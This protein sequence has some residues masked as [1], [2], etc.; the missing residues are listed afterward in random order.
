MS[1]K[2][3]ETGLDEP[4]EAEIEYDPAKLSCKGCAGRCLNDKDCS[5]EV[6]RSRMGRPRQ[7]CCIK[8]KM[9]EMSRRYYRRQYV[10][11]AKMLSKVFELKD[12]SRLIEGHKKAGHEGQRCKQRI[13][14]RQNSCPI[15]A[16][17]IDNRREFRGLDRTIEAAI[18][19]AR[20]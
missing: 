18:A 15:L 2:E 10:P 16:R 17:L 9:R 3:E 1:T 13:M 4:K 14:G 6:V 8:C 20:T 11:S 12:H 19:V 5:G 7:F